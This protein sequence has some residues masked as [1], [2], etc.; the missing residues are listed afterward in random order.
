VSRSAAIDGSHSILCAS[1][2]I[3]GRRNE[4]RGNDGV[5]A[6]VPFCELKGGGAERRGVLHRGGW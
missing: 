1:V 3:V 5:A 4:G 6:L 2:S